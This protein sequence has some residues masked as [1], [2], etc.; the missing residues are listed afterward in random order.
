[1]HRPRRIDQEREDERE[2]ETLADAH[3]ACAHGRQIAERRSKGQAAMASIANFAAAR[4][5]LPTRP[6]QASAQIA[7]R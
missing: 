6:R 5:R 4:A 1:M 2:N 7:K 3:G